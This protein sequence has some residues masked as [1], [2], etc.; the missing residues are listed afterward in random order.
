MKQIKPHDK[1]GKLTVLE[2]FKKECKNGKNREFAIVFC[3]CR[4]ILA[5]RIDSLRKDTVSCGC[6]SKEMMLTRFKSHGLSQTRAYRILKNIYSRCYNSLNNTYERYGARG[7]DVCD[8]W[9]F[10]VVGQDLATINFHNWYSKQSGSDNLT[11]DR[12]NNDKGYS[13]TN[14]RLAS[15]FEQSR[16]KRS[17][18]NYLCFGQEKC[19]KDWSNDNRCIISYKSLWWR[20]KNGWNIEE[21]LKTPRH[22]QRVNI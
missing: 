1:F 14:C 18:K 12:I 20:I 3:D 15:N 16:N 6:Y 9:N 17:N 2:T 21:A 5:V 13:P 10:D 4:N 7:I 22:K 19:L 11:I 8:E